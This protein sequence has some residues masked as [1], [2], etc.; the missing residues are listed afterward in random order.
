VNLLNTLINMEKRLWHG[1]CITSVSRR[2]PGR[3]RACSRGRAHRGWAD[4]F[5]LSC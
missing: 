4:Q 1:V 3:H 5:F 2:C